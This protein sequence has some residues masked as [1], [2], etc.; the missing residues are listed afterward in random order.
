MCRWLAYSGSPVL[1]REALYAP[2]LA[3]R[4]EPALAA[5]RR[6]DQR[7]RLRLRLVRRRGDPG[8][9]HSTE[10]AW[11]DQQPARARRPHQLAAV[12]RA[13]PGRDRQRRAAD[14]LPPLPPRALAVHAQ[15]LRQRVATIKRDLRPRRRPSLYPEI[16]GQTDSEV[17]FL[18]ALTFGLEDDPPAAVER[19]IGF[20][21]A[22]AAARRRLTRSRARSPPRTARASGRSGTRARA[23][24]ARSSTPLT[25]HAAQDAARAR[26]VGEVSEESR[27]IVSEPLG[28]VAGVWNEVPES[29]CGII[30]PDHAELPAY[31]T[32]SAAGLC[33]RGRVGQARSRD[34]SI[35]R[36]TRLHTQQKGPTDGTPATRTRCLPG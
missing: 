6:D 32:R 16:Q 10:P 24:R 4:P 3:D 12:L 14:E 23:S 21:E 1:I 9:F 19:A 18:L 29:S 17:L 33:P 11:N 34:R 27:L 13:H 20:V 15:R 36:L 35:R 26:A 5:R 8:V 28:D 2:E 22:V 30:G 31:P 7:R 25:F